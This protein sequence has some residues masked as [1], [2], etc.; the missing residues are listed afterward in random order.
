MTTEG[1]RGAHTKA[2]HSG[3]VV[4]LIGQRVQLDGFSGRSGLSRSIQN[5]HDNHVGVEGGEVSLGYQL[6]ADHRREVMQ[7]SVLRRSQR[8][9]SGG[10]RHFLEAET[11]AVSRW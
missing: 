5:L 7:R 10:H 2:L 8:G 3:F 11:S 6:L 1:G 9:R 4:N